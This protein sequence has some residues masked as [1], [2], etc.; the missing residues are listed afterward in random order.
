MIFW[1]CCCSFVPL[2]ETM[3]NKLNEFIMQDM[4]LG[5]LLICKMKREK[6]RTYYNISHAKSF[7]SFRRVNPVSVV[8]SI[9]ATE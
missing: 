1:C 2:I 9:H 6:Y 7:I 5:Y 8:G 4:I 3:V